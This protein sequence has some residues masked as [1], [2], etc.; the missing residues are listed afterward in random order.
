MKSDPHG[1][2]II[3]NNQF[4]GG[5]SEKEQGKTEMNWKVYSEV[6]GTE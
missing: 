4:A 2:C 3:F 6:W 1:I 5:T